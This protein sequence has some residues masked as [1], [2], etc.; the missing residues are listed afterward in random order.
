MTASR[1]Q[2]FALA[3]VL[4][5]ALSGCR[6]GASNEEASP[7]ANPVLAVTV[8]AVKVAPMQSR[9]SLLGTTAAL[10]H[11]ILRAPVAGR[12][13]GINLKIGDTVR[14]GQVV[15]HVLSHEVEAAQQGLEIAKRVDPQDA[16]ALEKSLKRYD[17][18]AGI[19]VAAPDSGIVSTQPVT[20]GQVVNYMDPIADLIDPK[21][22][23]VEA[24]VPVE[25]FPLVRPGMPAMVKSQ[26]N[27]SV[28][29]P[30]RVAAILPNF[31]PAG[32]TSPVRLEF[33]GKQR[34]AESGAPVVADVITQSVPNAIVIPTS[35]LFQDPGGG[36][37]VFVMGSD[38]R[39]HRVAVTLGIRAGSDAQ[40]TSG[41][42]AG[43]T[44]ITSGGY[45]LSDGLR[46]SA[47]EAQQ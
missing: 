38:H 10:H 28:E 17:D 8:A 37:H 6:G 44:V 7:N 20:S 16:P 3:A 36:Y 34:I 2:T 42:Q 12:V 29:M 9:L 19:A 40:V 22:I 21:S 39:A 30:A 13:L 14:K 15:A 18:G 27:P 23:Y 33:T 35:A 43:Q 4:L 46:V 32:A 25:D 47:A 1:S 24:A 45:A 41:L 5:L 31:N 11:V 26:L